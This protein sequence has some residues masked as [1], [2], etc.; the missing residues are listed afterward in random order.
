MSLENVTPASGTVFPAKQTEF[1]NSNSVSNISSTFTVTTEPFYI[2]GFNLD[3]NDTVTVQQV[4]GTGSGTS[5]ED[6]TPLGHP[7]QLKATQQCL[8]VDWPGTYRL[9]FSGVSVSAT[10]VRGY[11]AAF[12]AQ[13]I[14]GASAASGGGGGGFALTALNSS[15]IDLTFT[16]DTS[17]GTLEATAIVESNANWIAGSTTGAKLVD[18]DTIGATIQT[19][20]VNHITTLGVLASA[21]GVNVTSLGY[22]AGNS[23]VPIDNAVIIGASAAESVTGDGNLSGVVIGQ[24]ACATAVCSSGSVGDIFIGQGCGTNITFLR[25]TG[26]GYQAFV[27]ATVTDSVA[28]GHLAAN[29]TTAGSAYNLSVAVGSHAL[30]LTGTLQAVSKCVAVGAFALAN[31]SSGALSTSVAIGNN[32]GRQALSSG[33][34][35]GNLA[36]NTD[37]HLNPIIIGNS[38]DGTTPLTATADNDVILGNSSHVTLRTCGSVIAGG[39]ISASD[40]RLKKDIE[41]LSMALAR[42]NLSRVV[43]F[44][45]DAA[46]LNDSGLPHLKK[47]L[48]KRQAGVIAQEIESVFP[49]C[50]QEVAGTDGELYKFVHYDRLVPYLMSAI[51]E[52]SSRLGALENKNG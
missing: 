51:Q 16:G 9:V 45:W 4:T 6:W 25:A 34:Y 47:D 18:I 52:L 30:N 3:T 39:T 44:D 13:T 7:V 28:V 33:I 17:G 37:S 46:R 22:H 14:Y 15:S 35:I 48:L 19:L 8:R 41:P 27:H 43:S 36:G 1:F 20:S 40:S 50:V 31:A 29:S 42:I 26:V 38:V 11:P 21:Q 2:F 10:T 5:F 49:N 32:A 24:A 23:A 12:G